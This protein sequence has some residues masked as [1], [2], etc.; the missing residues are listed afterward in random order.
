MPI[1]M[2][3]SALAY[4]F[5]N[6]R[7]NK[8]LIFI[9]NDNTC[10][11]Y[12]LKRIITIL[13]KK[14]ISILIYPLNFAENCRIKV[15]TY[16]SSYEL[17]GSFYTLI[18]LMPY[19]LFGN[20]PL[21][22]QTTILYFKMLA[23]TMCA[24][25]V[26]KSIIP[27]ILRPY[28]PALW[29]I[30]L[31]YCLPF[32]S[33]IMLFLTNGATE[34]LINIAVTIMF[35]ILLVDWV[36]AIGISIVGV[37]GAIFIYKNF[38]V[39]DNNYF[40]FN[41][42]TTYLLIYQII[43]GTIIGLLFARRKDISTSSANFAASFNK[44]L[45]KDKEIELQQARDA[46]ST[47]IKTIG[48][49]KINVLENIH[50]AQNFLKN[51]DYISAQFQLN[52][53]E[54]Y[55][56]SVVEKATTHIRLKVEKIELSEL[57]KQIE[58][59]AQITFPNNLSIVDRSTI[60]EVECDK[61][62]LNKIIMQ[63]LYELKFRIEEIYK[64]EN[65]SIYID[66]SDTLITYTS[67]ADVVY[68]N[69]IGSLKIIITTAEH[70]D[71]KFLNK[72]YSKLLISPNKIL[73]ESKKLDS[74]IKTQLLAD[75]TM[76]ENILDAQYGV[77]EYFEENSDYTYVFVVPQKIWEIRPKPM[78]LEIPEDKIKY[79]PVATELELKLKK[80]VAIK[81]PHVDLKKV[82]KALDYIRT[83]HFHQERKSG[84]P[85]YM[86]P[87]EVARIILSMI[88][89]KSS[90]VYEKLQ[91]NQE[92][93]V[94]AAL[95]HDILEDTALEN[96]GIQIVFGH[97]VANIVMGLTK[98]NS[99]GRPAL[100]SNVQAFSKLITQDPLVVCIKIADRLHN[101]RTIDGHLSEQKRRDVAEE[102]LNFFIKPAQELGFGYIA[103]DLEAS[104]NFIIK[105][106]K[107]GDFTIKN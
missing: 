1:S 54:E 80:E 36:S 40:E 96:S 100:L 24:L 75:K 91:D 16:G 59:L 12:T 98:I 55:F 73:A 83:F 23:I 22:F 49:G 106:G 28:L 13:L 5:I 70:L 33:T 68:N 97:E 32:M 47:I 42:N 60:K 71:Y 18:L 8:S 67:D 51:K 93:I 48:G 79:W 20:I 105:N 77:S 62:A 2:F 9:K 44:Q 56:R 85:Y 69:T 37:F 104:C 94:L 31:T 61:V 87:I 99:A 81:A 58:N 6:I 39:T 34:Y 89:Y 14:F 45:V 53:I 3:A 10:N 63:A 65:L 92:I 95:L 27:D 84:E 66:I 50:N 52:Y 90:K 102:T 103:E 101:I 25:L 11:K 57:I 26:T 86:H 43:F 21:E 82:N 30:T 88:E 72:K 17:F 29:Y 46:Q 64:D 76:A 19:F 4:I 35:L 78:D 41:F 15:K 7:D 38:I 74:A 107:L